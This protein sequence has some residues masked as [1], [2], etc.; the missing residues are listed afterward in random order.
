AALAWADVVVV[1]RLQRER[2]TGAFV[3]TLGEFTSCFGLTRERA[4]RLKPEALVMHPG[5]MNRGVE[6]DSDVADDPRSL[7][8]RQVANG[9]PVRMA[10][11]FLSLMGSSGGEQ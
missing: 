4:L 5:P 9:V 3:P 8:T 2:G 7:I 6:I 10:V 11:L 1:L